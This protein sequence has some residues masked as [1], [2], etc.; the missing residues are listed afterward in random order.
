[1]QNSIVHFLK[2]LIVDHLPVKILR[3]MN[4]NSIDFF[5]DSID[6]ECGLKTI[7]V[8]CLYNHCR[9]RGVCYVDL[10]RN[11]T[12]CVCPSGKNEMIFMF[13]RNIVLRFCW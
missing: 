8:R 3:E 4:N 12:Q 13:I 2:Y 7:P 6:L 10:L 11:L 1:M 9:N 5:F